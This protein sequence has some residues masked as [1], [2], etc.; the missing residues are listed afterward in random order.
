MK[1]IVVLSALAMFALGAVVGRASVPAP[2]APSIAADV[3]SPAS[4]VPVNLPI[5]SF[6]AI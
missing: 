4:I 1:K 3:F 6:D 5:E 2:V